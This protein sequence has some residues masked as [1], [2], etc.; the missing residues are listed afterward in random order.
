V[1]V[2]SAANPGYVYGNPGNPP[3]YYAPDGVLGQALHYTTMAV[4]NG[5]G[6]TSIGTNDYYAG[7]GVVPGLQFGSNVSFSVS[8]WIRLPINYEAGDLPFFTDTAGSTFGTG[9]VFAP[10]Y[11]FGTASPNP[12]PTPVNY[13]GWALSVFGTGSGVGYYGALGSINDGNWHSLIH[14]IDRTENTIVTYL[15]GFVAQGTLESGTSSDIAILGDIDTGKSANIGQDPTG[16]YGETGSGDIDDL[17]VWRKALTPLEAA[18]IYIAAVSNQLSFASTGPIVITNQVLPGIKVELS[19]PIGTLQAST[20]V[21][22]P[23]T[24][25]PGA[26]SPYTNSVTGHQTF[27]RVKL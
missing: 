6:T 16:L 26:L 24:N 1:V 15:D 25:V 22:G 23:Y 13:G 12:T 7:V 5:T 3:F 10:A 14:V 20:N 21:V 11:G 4:T 8:Y 9:F 19:W 17:G 18:S 27:F 2:P